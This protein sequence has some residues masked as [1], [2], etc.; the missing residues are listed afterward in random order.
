MVDSIKTLPEFKKRKILSQQHIYIYTYLQN[1]DSQ[2][3]VKNNIHIFFSHFAKL[4]FWTIIKD[5]GTFCCVFFKTY[6]YQ[7]ALRCL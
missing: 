2:V 1:S 6:D 5:K 4:L 7:M 3:F